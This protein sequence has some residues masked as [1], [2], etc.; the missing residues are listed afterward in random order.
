MLFTHVGCWKFG[1]T[2]AYLYSRQQENQKNVFYKKNLCYIF[3]TNMYNTYII[4]KN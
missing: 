4:K 3:I 1:P 2:Y